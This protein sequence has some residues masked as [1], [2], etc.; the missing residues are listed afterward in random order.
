[1]CLGVD[2][3]V[4]PHIRHTFKEK[5]VVVNPV[6][7]LAIQASLTASVPSKLIRYTMADAICVLKSFIR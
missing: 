4:K 3:A 1:M 2:I 5:R 6:H 7:H